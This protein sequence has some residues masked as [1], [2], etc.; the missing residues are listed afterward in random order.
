MVVKAEEEVFART[1]I[2]LRATRVARVVR[3]CRKSKISRK[4][5]TSSHAKSVQSLLNGEAGSD[6]AA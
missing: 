3:R 1:A 6:Y 5:N 2:L 4:T